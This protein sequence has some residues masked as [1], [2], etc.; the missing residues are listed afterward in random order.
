M[1]KLQWGRKH[2]GFAIKMILFLHYG[3]LFGES[4]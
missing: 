4:D 2:L 1:E 3:P